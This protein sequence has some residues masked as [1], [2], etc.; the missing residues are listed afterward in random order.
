FAAANE[1][2]AVV[3]ADFNG[4]A[5]L[6]LAIA[7]ANCPSSPCGPGSVSILLGKP[8]GT[9]QSHVDYATGTGPDSVVAAD[10]NGDGNLDLAL[11]N[12]SD[13]T[14]SILLNNGDGTFQTHVDYATGTGPFVVSVGDFNRDGKLD[15]AVL[16]GVDATVS[17]LLGK[18]DG[19]FGA[20]V[21]YATASP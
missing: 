19:T 14:V 1:P 16:N 8:D 11:A 12:G 10:G 18:G 13:N 6:D 3:A 5:K 9:V 17:I 15:L 7:N 4:D 2:Y 21:D 20:H